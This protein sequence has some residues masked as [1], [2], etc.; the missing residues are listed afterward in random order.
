[1]MMSFSPRGYVVMLVIVAAWAMSLVRLP[2]AAGSEVVARG[3]HDV[4][5]GVDGEGH[6]LVSYTSHGR[7]HRLIAAGAINTASTS[8]GGLRQF[9]I[10]RSHPK[11]FRNRCAPYHGPALAWQIAACTAPDGSY[12]GVQSWQRNLP[13]FGRVPTKFERLAELRLSHWSG[14]LPTLTMTLH[15]P[16]GEWPKLLGTYTYRDRAVVGRWTRSGAPLAWSSRQVVVDT[17][18][19]P[20]G[21]GW[22][23]VRGL[24]PRPP[25]GGFCYVFAPSHRHPSPLGTR[26]RATAEGAGVLPDVSSESSVVSFDPRADPYYRG[27]I[28]R[29]LGVADQCRA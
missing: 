2:S 4:F 14:Q 17:W 12:W 11:A 13:A 10:T 16:I 5:L 19:S 22:R 27:L 20:L 24:R 21:T 8:P 9:L 18:N 28:N 1:M 29:L 3:A 26:F 25:R 23:R 6:A 15:W 7:S